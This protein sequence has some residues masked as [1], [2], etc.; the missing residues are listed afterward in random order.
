ML[1]K[2]RLKQLNEQL[3]AKT[4]EVKDGAACLHPLAFQLGQNT[5]VAAARSPH[6]WIPAPM[7]FTL[8]DLHWNQSP[9]GS[10]PDLGC[11]NRR[12]KS[13]QTGSTRSWSGAIS[14]RRRPRRSSS[15]PS[16]QPSS[17]SHHPS[18][19]H[20]CARC[21]VMFETSHPLL[22]PL[23]KSCRSSLNSSSPRPQALASLNHRTR[24]AGLAALA[25]ATGGHHPG[26]G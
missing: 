4:K 18:P 21:S 7:I 24:S 9:Q 22:P 10:H 26:R 8:W 5:D 16:W 25:P 17:T 3:D 2:A 20:R 12:C 19:S 1:V 6:T 13:R 11:D 14:R 15:K 23:C